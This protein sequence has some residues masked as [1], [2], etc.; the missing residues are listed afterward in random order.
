MQHILQEDLLFSRHFRLPKTHG[1][2]IEFTQDAALLHQYY[3]LR[4]LNLVD[5]PKKLRIIESTENDDR[6]QIIIIRAGVRVVGGG[7]V[8]IRQHANDKPLTI[9]HERFSIA[10]ALPNLDI[11]NSAYGE[12]SKLFL[13]EEYQ[14]DKIIHG[15][16][17][18]ITAKLK[19]LGV[20]YAFASCHLPIMADKNRH[21]VDYKI[22]I[23]QNFTPNLNPLN[24]L[25]YARLAIMDSVPVFRMPTS[26]HNKAIAKLI[27]EIKTLT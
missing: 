3:A 4:N 25:I 6:A 22:T 23:Y 1:L 17:Q 5:S 13:L 24:S 21:K 7:R 10:Q 11:G 15:M 14:S 20:R 16:Y 26:Q 19:E 8:I 9:E 18:C 27:E 2:T 12:I